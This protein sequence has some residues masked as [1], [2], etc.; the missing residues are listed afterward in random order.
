[1]KHCLSQKRGSAVN[2]RVSSVQT[3]K[4][5][6]TPREKGAAA[7]IWVFHVLVV[8]ASRYITSD[9]VLSIAVVFVVV[10]S[11]ILFALV[12]RPLLS[13]ILGSLYSATAVLCVGIF[14]GF[15]DIRAFEGYEDFIV[16]LGISVVSGG[17]MGFAIS[18]ISKRYREGRLSKNRI[19]LIVGFALLYLALAAVTNYVPDSILL[20]VPFV[21]LLLCTWVF[22]GLTANPPLGVI[23]GSG[24]VW[25]LVM[26]SA[27][28]GDMMGRHRGLYAQVSLFLG[29]LL[30]ISFFAAA[31]YVASLVPSLV[32]K[33]SIPKILLAILLLLVWMLLVFFLVPYFVK[34]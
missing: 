5:S 7:L 6:L 3:E 34:I 32:K 27:I 11:W 24:Y 26:Y 15:L 17:Y 30:I 23:L 13:T 14:G 8:L 25:L 12:A 4:T 19:R 2:K 21:G 33:R 22:F 28:D 29:Y 9:I 1:M 18:W 20:L 16:W 31:G 10:S